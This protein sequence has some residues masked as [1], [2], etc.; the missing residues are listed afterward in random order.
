M[1]KK[2]NLVSSQKQNFLTFY[3]GNRETFARLRKFQAST[4]ARRMTT[5]F[6]VPRYV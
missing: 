2:S 5:S 3:V 6:F 1:G 4:F